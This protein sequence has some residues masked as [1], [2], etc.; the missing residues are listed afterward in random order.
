[1]TR[2]DDLLSSPRFLRVLR[3]SALKRRLIHREFPV[4]PVTFTLSA[5]SLLSATMRGISAA[6]VLCSLA[7]AQTFDQDVK[8][9]LTNTCASCHNQKFASG[10]FAV[11][12]FLDPASIL[13]NR[14]AWEQILAK[15][16]SGE[17]PPKG[18]KKPPVEPFVRFVQSE[19][20]KAD[21]S[22]K[23]DPGR[24]VTHRL[25][26][27][28][29]ANAVRDLLGVDFRANE[30]FPAD[31]SVYGFDNIG[32][33]LT[34]SPTHTQK[35]L[36]AAE[37]IASRAVGGDPLP[38]PGVF[39][40]KDR[41]RRL[42]TNIIQVDDIV[43]YDAEYMVR[44]N[45]LGHRGKDDK[46]VTVQISV[47]GKPVKT[48]VVPVQI[49]AVNQ[50][51]G[52]TQ[53]GYV[54][55]RVFLPGGMHTFR[56]EFVN[57]EGLAAIPENQRFNNNRNIYPETIELSGPFPP[58]APQPVRKK[59]LICDPA[60]GAACV[61]RIL[62]GLARRGYRRPVAKDEV[63]E[64]VKV[65]DRAKDV[66][67]T[68]AQSLQFAVTKLLVSPNFLYKVERDP[69]PGT[70]A[71]ISDIELASR[72]SF[73][74]WS[75]IPDDELLKLAETNKLR[76]NLDAQVKRMIADP[77]STAFADNF[78]GQWL[79]VRG[80][81]GVK[82]DAKKFPEWSPELRDAMR[83]ETVK[84]FEAVLRGDRPITDFIDGKYTFLNERLAKHYGIEGV[85]G[86]EFRR[87]DLTTD[88]R[89]GVFTHASVLTVSSYPTRTS[90]V[91]RGKYL[92]ENLLN[93][94]PPP[95]PPD[96]PALNE[97]AVGTS[98]S[99]RQQ[100]EKHRTDSVCASCHARM[101]PLGFGL[102]N[103]DAVGKWRTQDGKLPVDSS[104]SFP[105]GQSFAGP[106]A[107]KDLLKEDL[108]EFARCLTEKLLTYS[109]GR[110]VE[111]YDRRT[112][113]DV[114]RQAAARENRFQGFIQAIVRSAPFQQ[115]R[116][117]AKEELTK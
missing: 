36:M 23:P 94:P 70:I 105:N 104:G 83:A 64:L 100:M 37:R 12:K 109:L 107:M 67:Y 86:P 8:S 40:R 7:G 71:P 5:P 78:A 55:A 84:F 30:E 33:A 101:D 96:V 79:E 66:G 44:V 91:L 18:I 2:R 59:V 46:P 3:A 26:R 102:E 88:Q 31:D 56:A 10:R 62:S 17:M 45:I 89:S 54:D 51:G 20:D 72:L 111:S 47:D 6:L 52:A 57:D 92:L 53:R 43:E 21:R 29:Y 98:T 87:I 39:N 108:P 76:A 11:E 41:G 114:V 28:E 9:V 14:D 113:Q 75:S 110:G 22:T 95:A 90:V 117:P 15:M 68:P 73:F 116:G 77:K 32:A 27:T 1:M 74:L 93:A 69:K 4:T 13:K 35:Y 81:D 48:E 34:V 103:Y 25:N 19:F 65:F 58:A 63:A 61:D 112:V 99:L 82:P 16:R 85:K 49:S 50:Q 97:E 38:K 42:D 106:A 60:T 80:L 115:R 24:V